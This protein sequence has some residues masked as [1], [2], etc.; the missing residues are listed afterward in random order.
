[1]TTRRTL[2]KSGLALPLTSLLNGCSQVNEE[3]LTTFYEDGLYLSG[4]FGPVEIEST[5]TEMKVSGTI[6]EELSGR[7]L[8]NGPNPFSEVNPSSHHW[9]IGDGMVH[10]IRLEEGRADWYRNRWVRSTRIVEAL[11]EA[12][13]G[14]MLTGGPNTNVIAHA[15]RVWALVESGTAPSE[16]NYELDTI[17]H[18]SGW[19]AYSA[20]PKYDP[21]KGE[22]H[23]I[24]YDWANYRDHVKYVVMGADAKLVKSLDIRLSGMSM[25]HDMAL[26]EHYAIIFDFPVTLS[27]VALGLGSDFPFRWD[28]K[29]QARLGLLPRDGRAED[30][31]WCN[32]S[33]CYAFH[34]V[35]AYEDESGNVVVDICRYDRMFAADTNGPFGDSLPRLDRWTVNPKTQN[36]SEQI[37][38]ERTQEFPRCH[39]ELNSKPY[40]FAYTLAVGDRSFPGV[41]KQDMKTGES[42]MFNFGKGRHGGEPVFVPKQSG[43]SE[44]DGYLM[45]FVYDETSNTSELI[46]LDALDLN[47]EA[48]ARVHLPVRVPY[49]FHGN[50]IADK[51]LI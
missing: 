28:E 14:R 11:G 2:L 43:T 32:V 19:G 3:D 35:N 12:V 26:T 34:P 17:G 51:S 50:W 46:I 21:D 44:D 8:R 30:I 7:F 10:G 48:L 37:I 6:P 38:D 24:S 47:Q 20:H 31:I 25:V 36:V 9:F 33:Q 40:Q 18:D 1:M 45:T 23:A 29:H 15:G 16:L 42:S 27:F 5:V 4:N 41:Y 22:L 49:G 13:N 39:P